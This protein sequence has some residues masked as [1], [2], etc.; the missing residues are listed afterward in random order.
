MFQHRDHCGTTLHTVVC[1]NQQMPEKPGK[2]FGLSTTKPDVPILLS[3]HNK[4]MSYSLPAGSSEENLMHLTQV[5]P[6]AVSSSQKMA[7][8]LGANLPTDYLKVFWEELSSLSIQH[9]PIRYWQLLK[10]PIPDC[11]YRM[12]WVKAGRS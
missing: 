2:K 11:I 3:T 7:V 5:V 6:E 10:L 8:K 1:T 4:P 9:N 12:I